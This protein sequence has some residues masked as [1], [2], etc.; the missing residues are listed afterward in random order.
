MMSK[1]V[2]E[3]RAELATRY[4]FDRVEDLSKEE[5]EDYYEVKEVVN[6]R[7]NDLSAAVPLPLHQTSLTEEEFWTVFE[8][9]NFS[10]GASLIGDPDLDPQY[11]PGILGFLLLWFN[12]NQRK[13]LTM[14]RTLQS[15]MPCQKC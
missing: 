3:M 13:G 2:S 1:L 11:I 4:N 7:I 14:L 15:M 12:S 10:G 6:A 5:V 9:V 8:D